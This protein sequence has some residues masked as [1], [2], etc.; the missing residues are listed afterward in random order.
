MGEFKPLSQ[1]EERLVSD[2]LTKGRIQMLMKFPFFG[3]LSLH[4]ELEQT[5]TLPTAATDGNKLYYNPHFINKLSSGNVNWIIMHEVLHAALKHIWRRGD[6]NHQ[7]FNVSAD[8]AI[9]SMLME[10]LKENRNITTKDLEPMKGMLYDPQ[11]NDM[12]AEQ[13]YDL[14]P[15]DP[16]ELDKSLKFFGGGNSPYD[17]GNDSNNNSQGDGQGQNSSTKKYTLDEHNW[18]DAS[19]QQN[20]Q[21]KQIDWEGKMVSAAQSAEGKGIGNLPGYLQ[22][23]INNVVKPQKNWRVLLQEFIQPEVDDYSFNPPDRRFGDYDFFLPDYNDETETVKD[24]VFMVD[25]SGSISDRELS[26]AYGEIVGAINQ[27]NGKLSGRLGFFDTEVYGLYDFESVEDVLKIKPE[28]CGGTSF[29]VIFKY[30]KKYME[31]NDNVAGVV[32]LTD[33]YASWPEESESM[34]LPTLWLITNDRMI[35]PWGLHTTLKL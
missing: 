1:E 31:T 7:K 24:I 3:I 19:T 9:H 23:V 29:T 34:G 6:R 8:Y 2:K 10:F 35:P 25:T 32:I 17:G 21:E 11:Y 30:L 26:V 15:D 12:S 5:Y 28:G 13:I 18:D 22:R 20:A 27:F 4:L 33:G 14:L 16:D